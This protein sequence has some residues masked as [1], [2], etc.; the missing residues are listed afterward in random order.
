[1][2]FENFSKKDVYLNFI[3]F[4]ISLTI[5][6]MILT[7]PTEV[8]IV[9]FTISLSG[10]IFLKGSIDL[11]KQ[12]LIKYYIYLIFTLICFISYFLYLDETFPF[13]NYPEI[14]NFFIFFIF[15]ILLNQIQHHYLLI[16]K[17]CIYLA[18]IFL[19]FSLPLH[20]FFLESSMLTATSFFYDFEAES[21]S[22]KSTL[23]IYLAL[24]FPFLIFELSKKVNFINT[25]SI[26]IFALSIFYI[27]SRTALILTLVGLIFCM[28]SFEKRLSLSAIFISSGIVFSIWFFEITPKKYNEMKMQT[29]IEYFNSYSYD[30]KSLNKSFS[31]ES[32]RFKYLKNSYEGFIEKPI[33]GHGLASFRRNNPVFIDGGSLIRYPVTHNDF[34]QIIYEL[35]LIG[36]ITFFGM[37]FLNLR[38]LLTNI[39]KT[40]SK[41]MFVQLLLLI[42]AI[43][44]I[45]L[46]DHILFWFIMAMTYK[47]FRDKKI[48]KP[49]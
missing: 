24:L 1:M 44:S 6:S 47:S 8:R 17:Y 45:N 4:F 2:F 37:F 35:G 32:A 21:Y 14:E 20:L 28:L 15:F 40:E 13:K 29:N 3:S 43:N 16:L 27:F 12:I 9:L 42:L 26:F 5:L 10:L 18:V 36:L 33:F 23:A 7:T 11:L 30:P 49:N 22:N 19:S 38:S 39:K 31:T 34:A 25:Y 46:I 48:P 41:I